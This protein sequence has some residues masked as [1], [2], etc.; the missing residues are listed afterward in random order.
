MDKVVLLVNSCDAYE[1]CWI[2]F[3]TLLK[4]YWNPQI[5]VYLNTETKSWSFEGLD[6]RTLQLYHKEDKPEWSERLIR[7]LQNIDAEYV[8]F[9]LDDFFL[10]EP[11]NTE[12]IDQCIAWM[13]KDPAITTFNF[14]PIGHG[15]NLPCPYPGFMRRPQDGEYRLNCQAG[16]WR[17]EHLLHDLRPHESAWLFE[18]L[19]SRRSRR[20]KDQQ[21]YA[22]IPENHVME[23]NYVEGAAL[24]RGKWNRH[25]KDIAA[26]ENLNIDF[27]RRGINTDISGSTQSKWKYIRSRLKPKLIMKALINRWKS[28]R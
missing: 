4:K 24:H 5:P 13:D 22:A 2:P 16:V 7:T 1:D 15:K 9:M 8:I 3:F 19:G 27:D 20:Y 21:F 28:Y 14:M 12:V 23:Y 17:R 11:V 18:T 10:E 25:T 26:K 6:I